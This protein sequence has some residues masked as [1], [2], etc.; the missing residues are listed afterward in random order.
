MKI[1]P[2]T[3]FLILGSILPAHHGY[4]VKY[5]PRLT[6]SSAPY[7]FEGMRTPRRVLRN[8]KRPPSNGCCL[9]HWNH[10]YYP[11][12]KARNY[13]CGPYHEMRYPSYHERYRLPRRGTYVIS[14]IYCSPCKKRRK[15]R[16]LGIF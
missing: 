10:S 5:N 4:W 1:L 12:V 8:R 6:S 15:G 2:I 7:S 3:V 13:E 9:K 11:R 16:F 14:E